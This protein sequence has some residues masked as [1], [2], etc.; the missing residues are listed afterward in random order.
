V[1]S[2][3]ID[4]EGC[5]VCASG[6]YKEVANNGDCTD[7]AAGYTHYFNTS[8]TPVDCIAC[9]NGYGRDGDVFSPNTAGCTICEAGKA[10]ETALNTDEVVCVTCGVGKY[11]ASGDATCTTCNAG[12]STAS[13]NKGSL[14]DCNVCD[15]GYGRTAA[16]DPNV[17]GCVECTPGRYGTHLGT[18]ACTDCPAGRYNTEDGLSSCL[19]CPAGR[20]SDPGTTFCIDCLAGK[21]A[22]IGSAE[23]TTCPGGTSVD[24]GQGT[25]AADCGGCEAGEFVDMDTVLVCT[26]CPPG[27]FSFDEAEACNDCPPGSFTELA[28]TPNNCELC[29]ISYFAEGGGSILCTICPNGRITPALGCEDEEECLSPEMNFYSAFFTMGLIIPM[30]FEYI[31]QSRYERIAFLRKER[32]TERLITLTQSISK[33]VFYAVMKA[34]AEKLLNNSNMLL[35]TSFFL[36]GGLVI[37]IIIA[38]FSFIS[39]LASIFFKAMIVWRGLDI[40][41]DFS[42]IVENAVEQL[43]IVKVFPGFGN[44]FV[45]LIELL[46]IFSKIDLNLDAVNITCKGALAPTELLFN[47]GIIGIAVLLIESDYQMYR[48]ISFGNITEKFMETI[49]QPV[50]RKWSTHR[51]KGRSGVSLHR[52]T[53][54]FWYYICLVLSTFTA[55]NMAGFDLFQSTLQ[56]MMSMVTFFAFVE[57]NGMHGYSD[58]CNGVAGFKNFDLYI[59]RLASIEAWLLF[60]PFIY[61]ISKILVPGLPN[62][63][64]HV[65]DALVREAEFMK[66]PQSSLLH[67]TKYTSWFSM[68]LW[69]ASA[70][71]GWLHFMARNLQEE[72]GKNLV[73][74]ARQQMEDEKADMMCALPDKE[75]QDDAG[76]TEQGLTYEE[77]GLSEGAVLK[78]FRGKNVGRNLVDDKEE[79]ER[80]FAEF[81]RIGRLLS[82]FQSTLLGNKDGEEGEEASEEEQIAKFKEAFAQFDEDGDGTITT[83]ELG[84]VM[85]SLGQNPTEVELT[86]IILEFD[87]DGNGEIDFPEFCT[88][89]TRKIKKTADDSAKEEEERQL[90]ETEE[91][92]TRYILDKKHQAYLDVITK[93]YRKYN[94]DKVDMIPVI[95]ER[96]KDRERMLI[97]ELIKKYKDKEVFVEFKTKE[98]REAEEA[99]EIEREKSE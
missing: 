14:A 84:T 46:K 39:M 51:E 87:A 83:K 89:M 6:K 45:P 20:Y 96:F 66:D 33:D 91:F 61:E 43:P 92:A 47:L 42:T 3:V 31:L 18:F 30:S 63:A 88:M 55:M 78:T 15:N 21:Y 95:M 72:T 16:L 86:D 37:N 59:A 25:S 77:L 82:R 98:E 68:D 28:G 57:D 38:V 26:A 70:S 1:N 27:K 80:E 32:V 75:T 34:S 23:C 97:D 49:L 52:T 4:D 79:D 56:Y 50:Y 48:S 17:A 54:G 35:K 58:E 94:P 24:T 64:S 40:G 65:K 69:L 22:A 44:I 13:A 85:R 36:I 10:A 2:G 90:M 41:V 62:Y 93:L 11:A 19:D 7:C 81:S 74:M 12:Y 5:S 9:D 8:V 29:P 73:T 71:E 60:T 76:I 67:I 99:E 53:S